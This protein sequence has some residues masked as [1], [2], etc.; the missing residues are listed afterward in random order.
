[1]SST[2]IS[3]SKT[4]HSIKSGAWAGSEVVREDCDFVEGRTEKAFRAHLIHFLKSRLTTKMPK[5]DFQLYH[6]AL[7]TGDKLKRI[8]TRLLHDKKN[9]ADA[10]I[11][12]TDVYPAF[13]SATHAKELMKAWV[14]KET[15]FYPHVALHDFEAWLLPYWER[16]RTLSKTNHRPPG[17]N[18]EQVNHTN[19]PAHRLHHE[20]ESGSRRDSYV[21]TRD[22]G[23]I[24]KDQDLLV[25]INACPEFKK[26]INSILQ[27][28][29]SNSV[30]K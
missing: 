6:G 12:L 8:V 25:S 11:A 21:K 2:W 29:D 5:L 26:F 1:M 27:L 4:T 23:R 20:F 24:L 14:G 7:P 10:V 30:L 16:I 22:V 17:K 15:R 9:P 19:P 28:C 13:K 3:G 18:P